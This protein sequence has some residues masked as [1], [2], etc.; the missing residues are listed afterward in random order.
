MNV[1]CFKVARWEVFKE[2]SNGHHY[3]LN[4][5]SLCKDALNWF[6]YKAFKL[7]DTYAD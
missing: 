6:D 5:L 1:P 4:S 2:N 3:F 7:R